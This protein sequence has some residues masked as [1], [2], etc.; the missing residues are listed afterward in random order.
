MFVLTGLS[1]FSTVVGDEKQNNNHLTLNYYFYEPIIEKNKSEEEVY[2]KVSLDKC[3]IN[4]IEN[5]PLLPIYG[6]NI[7]I[8][9]GKKVKNIEVFG[10]KTKIDGKYNLEL[11]K[12]PI[13][14]SKIN[15][16]ISSDNKLDQIKISNSQYPDK[17]FNKVCFQRYQGY[18]ILVLALYPVHYIQSSGELYYCKELELSIE[19]IDDNKDFEPINKKIH[20]KKITEMVDNPDIISTY[21]NNK[22]S[23]SDDSKMV[24]ITCESLVSY[25]Q[26]LADYHTNHGVTTF[27]KTIE[28]IK[29]DSAF[30]L[31]GEWGDNNP[32]NPFITEEI[33][34][35]FLF[36]NLQAWIRNYIRYAYQELDIEYV[37]LGGDTSIIPDKKLHIEFFLSGNTYDVPT[38]LYYGGL[39]NSFYYEE[40]NQEDI[41]MDFVPEVAVGRACVENSIEVNNFVDKTL[42]YMNSGNDP[43]LNKILLAGEYLGFLDWGY[44]DGVDY[45]GNWLDQMI[46]V[47]IED[48]YYKPNSRH[49]YR[50][51]TTGLPSSEYDFDKLYDK[52]V[53]NFNP[54]IPELTGWKKSDILEKLNDNYHIVLHDGHG[55]EFHNMKLDHPYRMKNGIVS[56]PSNDLDGLKNTKPFFVY[57]CACNSGA[58]DD[59]NVLATP[60]DCIAEYMTVKSSNGAFAGLWNSRSGWGAHDLYWGASLRYSREFFD[61]IFH[62][63]ITSI[64]RANDDSKVDNLLFISNPDFRM[65]HT[66]LNLFGDPAVNFHVNLDNSLPEVPDT[67]KITD[68]NTAYT[69]APCTFSTRSTDVDSDKMYYGWDWNNDGNIGKKEWT[70]PYEPGEDALASHIYNEAG[71]YTIKVCAMDKKLNPTDFSETFSFEILPNQKPEIPN[72]P[73]GEKKYKPNVEYEYTSNTTDADGDKLYYQFDFWY[74]ETVTPKDIPIRWGSEY[75]GWLGPFESGEEVTAVHKWS[76]EIYNRHKIEIDPQSGIPSD[77]DV[78]VYVKAKDE[79]GAETDRSLWLSLEP[80]RLI[81]RNRI[82]SENFGPAFKNIFNRFPFLFRL[83]E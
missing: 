15:K 6:A 39:D 40:E 2:D 44:D 14:V 48:Y 52:Y 57:S 24:I 56:L 7:L 36:D 68:L 66:G 47:C 69:F 49:V 61:A 8:P 27:F 29:A 37:L 20:S 62:E 51:L 73:S 77:V 75:S 72:Q 65:T 53:N 13:P 55:N 12:A 82:E 50:T 11:G 35:E 30:R 71:Q 67:P 80:E 1:S 59:Y 21:S 54:A 32:D 19:L 5:K 18:N 38:D 79:H 81:S 25:F 41:F 4:N 23:M 17:L 64:A 3:T 45:G 26:S 60:Y 28:E 78:K 58:F 46:D 42:A 22:N 10:Q 70:G 34:N 76:R 43:Y 63:E 33:E 16:A 9:D 31:D 74:V 83:M